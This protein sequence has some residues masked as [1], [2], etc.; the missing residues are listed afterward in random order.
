MNTVKQLSKELKPIY[1]AL[2]VLPKI[3]LKFL[4]FGSFLLEL[5]KLT[6][7]LHL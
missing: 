3:G 6:Y 2:S 7:I 4:N 5:L 1:S